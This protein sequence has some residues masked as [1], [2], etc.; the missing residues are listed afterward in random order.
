MGQSTDFANFVLEVQMTLISGDYE[1]VVFRINPGNTNQYYYFSI[2]QKG[3]YIL[4]RSMDTNFNDTVVI[5]QGASPSTL[6]GQNQ[7]NVLAVVANFGNI[8]LYVNH[9]RVVSASDNILSH[10][11]I[12]FF[13]G[14]DGTNAV[15]MFSNVKVWQ[16]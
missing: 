12:G 16:L 13:V 9:Q 3:D 10:G 8:D 6:I 11:Q 4:R 14:N 2:D 5:S 15:A 7:T 1:G